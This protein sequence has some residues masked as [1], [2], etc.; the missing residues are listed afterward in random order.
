[1]G[2]W[3]SESV[4]NIECHQEAKPLTSAVAFTGAPPDL[5]DLQSGIARSSLYLTCMFSRW[6]LKLTTLEPESD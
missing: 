1:M 5:A 2:K 6:T 4:S 3:A